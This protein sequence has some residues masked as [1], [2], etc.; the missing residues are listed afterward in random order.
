[1]VKQSSD[2]RAAI[3]VVGRVA[4]LREHLRWFD[5]R[6]LFGK[7]ILVTRPRNQAAELVEPLEALGAE[8]IE[9]PLIRIMPPE[10]V[11]LKQSLKYNDLE[12]TR[13]VIVTGTGV[14]LETDYSGRVDGLR[15][16][17]RLSRLRDTHRT[18]RTSGCINPWCVHR[19]Q[20]CDCNSTT[21]LNC[22]RSRGND[23]RIIAYVSAGHLRAQQASIF[24]PGRVWILLKEPINR[25]A[26]L[27]ILA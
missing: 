15:S 14:G 13:I 18:H 2:R 11:G 5:S 23:T 10:Q 17:R 16:L 1:M 4:A 6:P 27:V 9:S 19:R 8:A 26:H 24:S 20:R 21:G 12:F 3:L 25:R 7:R 22:N